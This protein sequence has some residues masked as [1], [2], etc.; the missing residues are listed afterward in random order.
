MKFS[1]DSD[2]NTLLNNHYNCLFKILKFDL[3]LVSEMVSFFSVF[4][5][6]FACNGRRSATVLDIFFIKATTEE[7]FSLTRTKASPSK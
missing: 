2:P 5:S 7:S 3:C 6:D 1:F 4:M